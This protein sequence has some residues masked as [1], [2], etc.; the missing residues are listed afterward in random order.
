MAIEPIDSSRSSL[1]LDAYGVDR[2]AKEQ[3]IRSVMG[4]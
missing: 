3:N 4:L 1:S 2:L